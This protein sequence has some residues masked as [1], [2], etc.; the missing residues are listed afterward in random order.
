[1]HARVHG[2]GNC[3]RMSVKG[4]LL[5]FVSGTFPRI[6]LCCRCFC[7]GGSAEMLGELCLCPPASRTKE[8]PPPLERLYNWSGDGSFTADF[9]KF[10][11]LLLSINSGRF[12]HVAHT[13]T[14]TLAFVQRSVT[15][16]Y[17]QLLNHLHL[18]SALSGAAVIEG[19]L[20]VQVPICERR[21]RRKLPISLCSIVPK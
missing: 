3:V 9:F 18:D 11:A 6:P 17:L 20:I 5:C 21:H 14:H 2:L 19:V 10:Q 7:F 15:H 13:H 16:L 4:Q 12:G 8:D 1:M